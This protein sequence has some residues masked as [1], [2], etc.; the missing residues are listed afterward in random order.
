MRLGDSLWDCYAGGGW[1]YFVY[2]VLS[3]LTVVDISFSIQQSHTIGLV[4]P[5]SLFT[6][7][8]IAFPILQVQSSSK[9]SPNHTAASF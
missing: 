8:L 4:S 6:F 9:L 2:I 7:S 5:L 3:S 1:V